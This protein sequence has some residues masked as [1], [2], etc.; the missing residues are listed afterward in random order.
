MWRLAASRK[1]TARYV[2]EHGDEMGESQRDDI[3]NLL[4]YDALA[5]RYDPTW[6]DPVKY[7]YVYD[8]PEKAW[9]AYL[10]V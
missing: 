5:E 6:A 2:Y 1:S 10:K 3:D 8:A 7:K 9:D 4:R